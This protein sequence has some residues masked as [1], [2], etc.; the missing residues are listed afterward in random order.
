MLPIPLDWRTIHQTT[1]DTRYVV[2][3]ENGRYAVLAFD[4]NDTMHQFPVCDT[5]D[6]ARAVMWAAVKEHWKL[7]D[8]R[9]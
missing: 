7:Q 3:H 2:A 8:A 9:T 6:Q 5:E 1:D 4:P